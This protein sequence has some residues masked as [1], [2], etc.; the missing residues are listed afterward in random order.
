M[1]QLEYLIALVS[2][3]VGLALAD[4]AR[5]FRELVRPRRAV[6]WHWLPLTWTA[7]ILLI[8]VQLWWLSFEVLQQTVFS[9]AAVFLPY[10]MA[11]LVLYL[12]CAFAL[13]DPECR[14]DCAPV[15]NGGL[16]PGEVPTEALD[17]EA[18]YFSPVHRRWFF[19]ALIALIVIGQVTSFGPS[20]VFGKATTADLGV[21]VTANVSTAALLSAL[22]VTDRK[23]VHGA[24]TLLVLGTTAYTFVLGLPALG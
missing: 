8:V 19:G 11:F 16:A 15:K 1:S 17:M 10:L 12:A 24:V 9:R 7:V 21:T 4:L 13:P 2:I 18:F 3:I 14:P 20:V 23:W 6:R 5:S 22:I